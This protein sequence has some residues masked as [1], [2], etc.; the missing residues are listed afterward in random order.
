MFCFWFLSQLSRWVKSNRRSARDEKTSKRAG[1]SKTAPIPRLVI[2]I[3]LNNYHYF[4]R[5]VE[6]IH[7]PD[8]KR[9]KKNGFYQ[10]RLYIQNTD[11]S[12]LWALDHLQSLASKAL[13]GTRSKITLEF[14]CKTTADRSQSIIVT[15]AE[16][17]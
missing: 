2:T 3:V 13:V 11:L 14:L 9:K 15:K 8:S 17:L 16:D 7:A 4:N 5:F 10:Y 12:G 1:H 6:I